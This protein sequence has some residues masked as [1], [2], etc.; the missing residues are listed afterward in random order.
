MGQML[1]CGVELFLRSLFE[2]NLLGCNQCS[3]NVRKICLGYAGPVD[4]PTMNLSPVLLENIFLPISAGFAK[5]SL[6]NL[7]L[8]V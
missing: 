4:K 6:V 2:V 1:G 5:S 3:H 8:N 7:W